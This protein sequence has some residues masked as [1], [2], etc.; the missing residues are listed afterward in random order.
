MQVNS[1]GCSR[2]SHGSYP[3]TGI[4]AVSR[5][6]IG[7][8]LQ[9]GVSQLNGL[10]VVCGIDID[11]ISISVQPSAVHYLS[12]GGGN[13]RVTGYTAGYGSNI[14]PQM[15]ALGK[16]LVY[17]SACRNGPLYFSLTPKY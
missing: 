7:F 17:L 4:D 10:S 16:V 3:L 12:R 2:I 5:L 13:H 11:H 8:F 6:K 1:A 14:Q 15:S 9:M